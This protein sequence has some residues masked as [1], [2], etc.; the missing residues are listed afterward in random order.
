MENRKSLQGY[1][2]NR[3]EKQAATAKIIYALPDTQGR[4]IT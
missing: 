1:T 3:Y 2:H 4:Q